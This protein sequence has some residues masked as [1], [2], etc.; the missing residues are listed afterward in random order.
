V[1]KAWGKRGL[2]APKSHDP[3]RRAAVQ[4]ATH[5]VDLSYD[6]WDTNTN[7]TTA[8]NLDL[9]LPE[10]YLVELSRVYVTEA[11]T[12]SNT[13]E[14][15]VAL[16]VGDS[17]TADYYLASTAVWSTD[18][19][20]LALPAMNTVTVTPTAVNVLHTPVLTVTTE[21]ITYD[22]DGSGTMVTNTVVTG[23]TVASTTNAVLSAA[24]AAPAQRAAK[25]TAADAVM[26]FTL[27]PAVGA[28]SEFTAG[29][30]R[31]YV[32]ILKD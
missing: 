30:L 19:V 2:F 32:R 15:G 13:N 22:S 7:A 1:R 23:V 3:E 31:A 29:Q 28:Q 24:S 8:V 6:D 12:S 27:T 9:D 18:A 11:F 5:M 20:A 25:V 17:S 16:T 4:G 14:T 10:G 26:R 21:E